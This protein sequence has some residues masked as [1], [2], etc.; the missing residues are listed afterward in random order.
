MQQIEFYHTGN[1]LKIFKTDNWYT[2]LMSLLFMEPSIIFNF[3]YNLRTFQ[4]NNYFLMLFINIQGAGLIL[5]L[6]ASCAR[7]SREKFRT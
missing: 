1:Y 2:K 6:E 3:N 7:D 5:S 4:L